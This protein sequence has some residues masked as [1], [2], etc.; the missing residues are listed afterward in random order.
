[1]SA[2]MIILTVA[3]AIALIAALAPVGILALARSVPTSQEESAAFSALGPNL[4]ACLR[5]GTRLQA[6]RQ[7]LRAALSEALYQ[8]L[9][10]LPAPV[11]TQAVEAAKK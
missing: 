9:I 1:M 7:A 8:R 5:A 2:T 6:S 10:A 11:A 3:V 4:G